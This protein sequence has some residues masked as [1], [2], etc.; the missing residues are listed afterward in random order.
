VRHNDVKGVT[1]AALPVVVSGSPSTTRANTTVVTARSTVV[2]APP[3]NID[4]EMTLQESI[5]HVATTANTNN[6]TTVASLQNT[7]TSSSK[8]KKQP[9]L[10]LF[11]L[12]HTTNESSFR[13]DNIRAIESIF[14]HHPRAQ[15][16]L[17]FKKTKKHQTMTQR[18]VQHLIQTG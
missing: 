6:N 3:E 7:T 16:S 8:N 14:F 11:H 18:P 2:A 12:V 1:G 13:P 9:E 10:L 5:V 4:S 15:L 17:Y